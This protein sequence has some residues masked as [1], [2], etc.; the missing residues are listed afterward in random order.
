MQSLWSLRPTWR[1]WWDLGTH[2]DL[3]QVAHW[4]T[5]VSEADFARLAGAGV[6][7]VRVPVAYWWGGGRGVC[8]EVQV[9][10]GGPRGALPCP[11][12]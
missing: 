6:S 1:G 4:D 12:H 2:P 3:P 10:G 9:L 8:V 11:Q 5:F 7:H